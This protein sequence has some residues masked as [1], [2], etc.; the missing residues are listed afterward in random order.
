MVKKGSKFPM[1]SHW[2]WCFWKRLIGLTGRRKCFC[3]GGVGL[4]VPK[5]PFQDQSLDLII[6]RFLGTQ[7]I[8]LPISATLMNMSDCSW[9]LAHL[10]PLWERVGNKCACSKQINKL[11]RRNVWIAIYSMTHPY[12]SLI[13][14]ERPEHICNVGVGWTVYTGLVHGMKYREMVF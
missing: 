12:H 10:K 13:I 5:G 9:L 3:G 7:N 4:M 2:E 14:T 11:K 6:L 1:A 8:I